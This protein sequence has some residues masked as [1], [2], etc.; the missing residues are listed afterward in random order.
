[1]PVKNAMQTTG[2]GSNNIDTF[3]AKFTPMGALTFA[4]YFG[5]GD[6]DRAFAITLDSARNIYITGMTNS[7]DFPT[8][9]APQPG[10]AGLIDAYILKLDPTGK[11]IL[12]STFLGGSRDDV[13]FNIVVDTSNN[14]YIYGQTGSL[15]D[16]PVQRPLQST[17]TGGFFDTF[18]TKYGGNG[19]VVFSTYLGGNN[20]DNPGKMA[21]DTEGNVYLIGDTPS[22]DFP[23]ANAAQP[24][25]VGGDDIFLI[26]VSDPVI[27][28]PTLSFLPNTLP[29]AIINSF[30]NQ[31]ISVAAST[32]TYTFSLA[33]KL[34]NGL[35]FNPSGLIFGTPTESGSFNLLLTTTDPN[36][37]VNTKQFTLVVRQ[38]SGDF[39]LNIS[40]SLQSIPAGTSTSF[41]I[42]L[43]GIN[44]FSQPVTINASIAPDANISISPLSVTI[45]S[46]SRTTFTVNTTNSTPL[47]RYPITFTGMVGSLVRSQMA[48]LEVTTNAPDFSISLAPTSMNLTAGSSVDFVARVQPIRGFSSAV[49]LQTAITPSTSDLT[50]T[51]Q[52]A[53]ITPNNS[54]NFTVKASNIASGTFTLML[55]ATAGQITRTSTATVNVLLP[56]FQISF[57]PTQVTIT[58]GQ[59]GQFT[60]NI[61]R[62]GGFTGNVTVNP[63]PN[64]LKALKIKATPTSQTTNT[65]A[66]TFSFKIKAKA[67]VGRQQLS[68][69]GR[70]DQGNIRSGTL[71]LVIQ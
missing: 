67:P 69:T 38:I 47:A 64:Q 56:D 40:P 21:L 55:T 27:N 59:S 53:T 9:K 3:I 24:N 12:F 42:D 23:T 15:T 70:D 5:A 50:I 22:L 63:D 14:I 45:A 62:S 33:G 34:P 6:V 58:R 25:K 10:K 43:Q 17:S 19:E 44:N 16:F 46:G 39:T 49:T 60:A 65:N 57:N 29:E 61:A 30:Y 20:V 32:T 37:C 8:V 66:V 35:M 2:G 52:T 31:T 48:T 1:L 71:M 41:N 18:L 36:G 11:T 68:F 13:G 51:P 4:T 28:C 26:K 7:I 54:A